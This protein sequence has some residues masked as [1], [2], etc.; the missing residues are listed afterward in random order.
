MGRKKTGHNAAMARL[1]PNH[2]SWIKQ[3]HEGLAIEGT[4]TK[5]GLGPSNQSKKLSSAIKVEQ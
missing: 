5:Q 1:K 3:D 4:L 2:V